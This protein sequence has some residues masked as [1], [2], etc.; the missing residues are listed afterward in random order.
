MLWL[1][2]GGL[3]LFLLLG[4]LRAFERASV[5]IGQGAVCLDRRA[6]R[7]QSGAAADPDRTR[8]HRDSAH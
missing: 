6:R 1:L 2:L 5:T 4:G 7:A 3:V 8:R